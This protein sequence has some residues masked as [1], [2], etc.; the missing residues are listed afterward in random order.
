MMARG[1]DILRQVIRNREEQV[2]EVTNDQIQEFMQTIFED[3]FHRLLAI[4]DMEQ[5]TDSGVSSDVG[6]RC[7]ELAVWNETSHTDNSDPPD[8]SISTKENHE[9]RIIELPEGLMTEDEAW[10]LDLHST[11]TTGIEQNPMEL[12]FDSFV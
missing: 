2:P 10:T 4:W 12:D 8:Q 7:E 1:P 3:V 5:T 9:L 11:F 6:Y